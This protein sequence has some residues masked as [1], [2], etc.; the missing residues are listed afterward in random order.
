[1]ASAKRGRIRRLEKK[2]GQVREPVEAFNARWLEDRMCK[3]QLW[4]RFGLDYQEED[5]GRTRQR[6]KALVREC[7]AEGRRVVPEIKP[8]AAALYF[9]EIQERRQAQILRLGV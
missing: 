4:A 5:I 2:L 3:A 8:D 9:Q 1:M 7:N 6:L